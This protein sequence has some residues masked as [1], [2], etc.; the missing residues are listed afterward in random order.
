MNGIDYG[1]VEVTG[2]GFSGTS[3][4][5]ANGWTSQLWDTFDTEFEDEVIYRKQVTLNFSSNVVETYTLDDSTSYKLDGSEVL[6]QDSTHETGYIKSIGDTFIV[7]DCALNAQFNTVDQIRVLLKDSSEAPVVVEDSSIAVPVSIDEVVVLQNPLAVDTSY[8]IYAKEYDSNGNVIKDIR[9]DDPEFSTGDQ[10]NTNA[11]TET[12]LGDG[13]T[14]ALVLSDLNI[15]TQTETDSNTIVLIFRKITS[16]GSAISDP[17]SFDNAISGGDLAY[18]TATGIRA[19]DINIDGDGFVTP[20]TSKGPEEIVPGQTLDTVDITV[21]ES[22]IGGA[23]NIVSRSYT[24]DGVTT[25]FDLGTTPV[26]QENV[27]VKVDNVI[28]NSSNYDINY[29]TK[30]LHFQVAP[31]QGSIIN[32]VSL[33]NSAS[34]VKDIETFKGDGETVEFLT[35][36]KWQNDLEAFVTVNGKNVPSILI[37]SNSSYEIPNAAVLRFAVPPNSGAVI[38]TVIVTQGLLNTNYSVVETDEFIADGSTT[39]FTLSNNVFSQQPASLYTIVQVND[40]ILSPG[41][42]EKFTVSQSKQFLLNLQQ[43]PAGTINPTEIEVYLNGV[44]L[45]RTEDWTVDFVVSDTDEVLSSGVITLKPGV[46]EPEDQLEINL[47]GLG[48]Y[49]F[50]FFDTDNNFISQR[51]E[52]S[53]LPVLNLDDAYSAGDKITVYNFSNHDS[54]GIERIILEVTEKTPTTPGTDAYFEFRN[55]QKGIIKLRKPAQDAQWVWVSLNGTLLSPSIDYAVT[56]DNQYVELAHHPKQGDKI[57]ILHFAN[58]VLQDPFGWRQFKDMLNRT[59]YKRLGKRYFLAEDLHFDDIVIEVQDASDLPEPNYATRTPGVLFLDKERIEYFFKDGNT[60][61]QIRRGTLG[62]GVKAVYSAGTSFMEQGKS[63][64]LPYQDTTYMNRFEGDGST[65]SFTP[66]FE[67]ENTEEIEVFVGG[68]RLRSNPIAVF[69]PEIAQDSP[70]GDVIASQ[71]Y[72]VVEGAVI[73]ASAPE[74]KITVTISKKQGTVWNDLGI[75]LSQS[76][77][78]VARFLNESSTDSLR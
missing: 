35:S 66:S 21:F 65:M 2:F 64:N 16:D 70:E 57:D 13:S 7:L 8:N 49:R 33:G 77:T 18:Q 52:D 6:V 69:D 34:Q 47:I 62:T 36:V 46:G 68:T 53:T 25:Q 48:N 50:G 9:L 12:M 58:D 63:T 43:I 15:S 19:E 17:D 11:V 37:E 4:W 44:L 38:N 74:N 60:L 3:G 41:Y 27:F 39:Q 30:T 71:E 75:P 73:L 23:S 5:D 10:T 29:Q 22:A 55:L 72:T 78:D 1:G 51:G 56:T 28:Q 45:T 20:T 24:G 31:E 61:K 54:Q 32:L 14:Q 59:H 42:T 40:K 26:K 76:N 67:I